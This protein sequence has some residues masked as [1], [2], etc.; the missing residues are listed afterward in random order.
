M[1]TTTTTTCPHDWRQHAVAPMRD[2]R[3][4]MSQT[5]CATCGE[6]RREVM[7]R[8]DWPRALGTDVRGAIRRLRR[9]GGAR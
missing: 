5:V 9:E 1:T 2:R 6:F 4:V 3:M 8:I 7:P